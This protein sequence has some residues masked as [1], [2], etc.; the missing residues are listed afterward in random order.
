MKYSILSVGIVAVSIVLVGCVSTP[1][2]PRETVTF[3]YTP[4][5]SEI[6]SDPKATIALIQTE[7]YEGA[8]YGLMRKFAYA[9]TQDFQEILVACGY[10]VKGPFE[11]VAA[12]SD[13]EKQESDGILIPGVIF[14]LNLENMFIEKKENWLLAGLEVND[15][16][17]SSYYQADGSAIV[18]SSISLKLLGSP[19]SEILSEK[20]I[21]PS[22]QTVPLV[23]D[24]KYGSE[25]I[26]DEGGPDFAILLEKDNNLYS[27]F[28]HALKTQYDVAMAETHHYFSSADLATNFQKTNHRVRISFLTT[29]PH[30]ILPSELTI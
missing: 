27:D 20:T 22:L 10:D 3:D 18:G 16:D 13:A 1:P 9:T 12:M 25:V 14:Y 4:P 24:K 2:P 8:L 29:P 17:V 6:T 19:V 30:R 21:T 26:S 23:G 15:K 28:G 5:P 7:S 11:T